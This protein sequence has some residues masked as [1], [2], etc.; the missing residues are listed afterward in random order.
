MQP[1]DIIPLQFDS[2][3]VALSFAISVLGAYV[4]LLAASRI[5]TPDN[6][7]HM[8]YVVASAVALGGVGIWGMHFIGMAAQIIP[9]RVAYGAPLTLF[10]L[11]VAM[12]FSGAALWFVGRA[13]FTLTRCAIAGVVA[14]LGVVAMH[15]LGM[16]SMRMSAVFEW[17]RWLVT[18]S[19]V[20]AVVAATVALWLAFNLYTEWQRIGAAVLMALAV[21][22]M[23][24]LGVAAGAIVCTVPRDFSG[25]QFDGDV[26]PYAVFLISLVSLIV[27]RVEIYRSSRDS[28][29]QMASKL[30]TVLTTRQ[31][32]EG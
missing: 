30:E 5:R 11:V 25:L 21:C 23:H 10:S 3:L 4:A 24:Y 2:G 18:A 20:V 9:S 13:R 28:H 14:G 1:G 12:A 29:L 8:G 22:G 19:F 6:R 17:N 32:L 16:D 26:L 7:T 27:M 31:Q 15:Y